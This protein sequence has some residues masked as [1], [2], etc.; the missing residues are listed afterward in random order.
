MTVL[1]EPTVV[2]LRT[3][4]WYADRDLDLTFPAGW[5]VRV[6]R[7]DLP[8]PLT[9]DEIATCVR[10]PA[11]GPALRDL[12]RDC[13]RVSILVDDLT[14]PTPAAAILPHLL[15]ELAVA[16]VAASTVTVLVATGA[17]RV[18]L[19]HQVLE[20]KLGTEVMASCRVVV[21]DHRRPTVRIGTTSY[22]TPVR[23]DRE[24]AGSDLLVG[25]GGV[26]PQHTVGFG[27][28]TKIVLGALGT[29]SIAALHYRHRGGDGAYDVDNDFR[30]DLDEIARLAGLRFAVLGHVDADRALV[31]VSAGEPVA[32]HGPEVAFAKRSFVAAM[33]GDADVVVANAYPMD[34]SLTF[35][36]SKGVIPFSHAR[37]SA[38]RVLIAGCPEGVGRHDMFPLQPGT[39]DRFRHL[40]R[41]VAAQKTHIPGRALHSLQRRARARLR[42]GATTAHPRILWY[43]GSHGFAGETGG[44]LPVKNWQ[45]LLE[46]VAHQQGDRADLRVVVYACAPLQVLGAAQVN[47]QT[48]GFQARS[49]RHLSDRRA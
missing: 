6:L 31:R 41:K 14:R 45:R 12:A 5:D 44:L 17:H 11:Q 24:V 27:G 35:A 39:A 46:Q 25:V 2:R 23:L 26:Y 37:P 1:A 8:A 21:H 4:A 29:S 30:H 32:I 10:N 47:D 18:S 28:G 16:G 40:V 22:G 42:P 20:T 15:S 33:P 36:R 7:P 34:V 13:R 48:A 49:V 3:G 19:S 43:G 38:S 9:S